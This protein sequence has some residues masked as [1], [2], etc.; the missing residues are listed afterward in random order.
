ME[1][2]DDRSHTGEYELDPAIA[3]VEKVPEPSAMVGLLALGGLL[4]TTGKGRNK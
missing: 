1:E 2:G 4:F 3:S